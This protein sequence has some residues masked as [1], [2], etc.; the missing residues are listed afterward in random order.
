MLSVAHAY[1]VARI[2]DGTLPCRMIDNER[3]IPLAALTAH[4]H[5]VLAPR[6]AAMDEIYALDREFGDAFA[7]PP[8]K[9]DF[10][11]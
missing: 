8:P 1:V 2:E 7:P 11:R 6:R 3:R 5:Q 10:R 4:S 9:N